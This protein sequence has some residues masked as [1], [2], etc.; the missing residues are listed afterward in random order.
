MDS[1]QISQL[2]HDALSLL[3]DWG[4]SLEQ[5]AVI[6][7]FP[8]DTRVRHI[9]RHFQGQALPDDP[10]IIARARHVVYLGD[11]LRTTY[12]TNRQMPALWMR[13]PHKRFSGRS[14]MQRICQ[15]DDDGLVAVITLLDCAYAWELNG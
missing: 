1:A 10:Q 9:R 5:T 4:A 13:S 6:L 14:P 11:A 3:L 15:G 2:T 12:P 8:E 7:G